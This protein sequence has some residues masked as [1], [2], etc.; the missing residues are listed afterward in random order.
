MKQNIL[1]IFFLVLNIQAY[2]QKK[3]S[4]NFETFRTEF[5]DS[6][7]KINT[8]LEVISLDL[9][10]KE[11][12][13]TNKIEN[14]S[15]IIEYQN[16]IIS[17]YG[18]IFTILAIFI[19][20]ITLVL[21]II[22]YLFG[23]R[24]SQKA[25]KELEINMD[26]RLGDYIKN[27]RD[28]EIENALE[29]IRTGNIEQKNQATSFLALSQHQGF[30]DNQLFK[31]YSILNENRDENNVKS[32]LAFIL[33][34]KRNNYADQLFNGNDVLED[35][36]IKQMAFLYYSKIGFKNNYAGIK[37]ILNN[38]ENQLSEFSTL[39]YN[40]MQ[41][42][43][44]ELK[45]FFNDSTII[46]ILST[47]TLEKMKTEFQSTLSGLNMDDDTYKE[48]ALFKKVSEIT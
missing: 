40:I 7:Q 46:N 1:I 8:E 2:S 30:N 10:S 42:S 9:A 41:Y 17:S 23:I 11:I 21:P 25:L 19:A 45:A 3:T 43:V 20:I 27:Q 13:L 4:P 14:A 47:N 15:N 35:P 48:S 6:I 16:S 37:K 22:T 32:Q 18:Q 28:K 38:A 26:K 34:S 44:E 36:V 12:A 33:T 5:I 39:S 24:P 29:N 31:I